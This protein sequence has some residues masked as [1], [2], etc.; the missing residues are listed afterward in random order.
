MSPF[1]YNPGVRGNVCTSLFVKYLSTIDFPGAF[2][3]GLHEIDSMKIIGQYILLVGV[4]LLCMLGVLWVGADLQAPQSVNGVWAI[5]ITSPGDA[6]CESFNAWQGDAQL[7]ISQSGN[8]LTLQ[9]NNASFAHLDGW[10]DG[11]EITAQGDTAS[12]S[13]ASIRFQAT[14][15]PGSTPE[16]MNG[17]LISSQ[18]PEA[19]ALDGT[20]QETPQTAGG[21]H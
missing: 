20:R 9:F 7:V 10:L 14:V 6:S 17:M 21:T 11:L 4:P 19:A 2:S 18:C 8:A 16:K 3:P 13:A 1:W 5:V 12:G 15:D